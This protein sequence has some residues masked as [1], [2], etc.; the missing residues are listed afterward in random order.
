LVADQILI[1]IGAHPYDRTHA[2]LHESGHTTGR[3][4]TILY[5]GSR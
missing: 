1:I 3:R 2:A 5:I 4:D